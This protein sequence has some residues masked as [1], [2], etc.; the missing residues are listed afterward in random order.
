VRRLALEMGSKALLIN[1]QE[2][3]EIG[4]AKIRIRNCNLRAFRIVGC[5]YFNEISLR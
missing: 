4:F 2:I 1:W 5:S 3:N